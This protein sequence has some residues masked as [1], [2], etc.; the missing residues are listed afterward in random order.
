VAIAIFLFT[1]WF[2]RGLLGAKLATQI[3]DLWLRRIFGIAMFGIALTMI[4][5]L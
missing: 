3:S 2:N 1:P 5:S 4:L